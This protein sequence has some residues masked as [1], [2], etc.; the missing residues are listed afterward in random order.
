MTGNEGNTP[1]AQRAL[2][3]LVVPL[4]QVA[5]SSK[6]PV[7]LMAA[8]M[9]VSCTGRLCSASDDG[10]LIEIPNPPDGTL[11]GSTAA[12]TYP[13]NDGTKGFVSEITAV[14]TGQ[15]PAG[16]TNGGTNGAIVTLA[17][18]ARLQAGTRRSAVRVPV[19]P[20]S[21]TAAI[22]QGEGVRGGV[23]PV[24]ISLSGL[25][26]EMDA[27]RAQ[28]VEVGA[29]LS[30]RLTHGSLELLL[31]CEVRRKDGRRFGLLF[32]TAGPVAGR[33]AKIM[34][35]LQQDRLLSR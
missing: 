14:D 11:L 6:T 10:V 7:S 29:V 30:L 13:S 15:G 26:I 16:G 9:S 20:G 22:V 32:D 21:L 24:D 12:V 27:L 17:I 33:M 2:R 8:H 3:S 5:C 18:P 4:L 25:L 1:Q 35:R 28:R 31:Q 19:P 23:Q 34:W